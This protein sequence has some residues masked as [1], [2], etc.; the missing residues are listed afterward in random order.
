MLLFVLFAFLGACYIAHLKNK[1]GKIHFLSKY[2]GQA[3][4]AHML[5]ESLLENMA[6]S[7]RVFLI[8]VHV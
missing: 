5:V 7:N 1:D 8:P 6:W 3:K 2:Y 4:V